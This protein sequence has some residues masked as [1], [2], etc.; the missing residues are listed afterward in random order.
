MCSPTNSENHSEPNSTTGMDDVD[1]DAEKKVLRREI[2][3][4]WQGV[5]EHIDKLVSYLSCSTR[6]TLSSHYFQEERFT[7]DRP[8]SFSK[9]L[10]RLPST[11]DDVD[12]GDTS[13]AETP[14]V[15][16]SDLPPHS[17]STIGLE[18]TLSSGPTTPKGH[19]LP[20]LPPSTPRQSIRES[21]LLH[22]LQ[23]DNV[24]S[25]PPPIAKDGDGVDSLHRLQNLRHSFQRTEQ[26]LYALLSR[27][28]IL[29]LNDVRTSFLSAARGAT[30]RLSAWQKKHLLKGQLTA[31]DLSIQEP[32]WWNK[33]CHAIPGGNI[34]V[35]E[36]DWGSIIA[37]T[38]GQVQFLLVFLFASYFGVVLRIIGKN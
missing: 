10:P 9:L 26:S 4:W 2:K 14:K 6:H 33:S 16:V 12:D 20:P 21:E 28:S 15:R 7:Q 18:S 32:E 35:R 1:T 24:S 34:I 29:S 31:G 13:T 17:G 11:G 19:A 38:L 25:I 23:S 36:D 27:T 3:S 8:A 5:A 22:K 37:F 30:R